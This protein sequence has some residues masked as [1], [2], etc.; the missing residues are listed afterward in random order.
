M[1]RFAIAIIWLVH[2]LPLRA[3]ARVG[4]AIGWLLFWLIPERR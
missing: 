2:F 1:S 4:D 3:I